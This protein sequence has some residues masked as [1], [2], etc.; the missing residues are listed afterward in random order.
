[1]KRTDTNH[2]SKDFYTT[3]DFLTRLGRLTMDDIFK[4]LKNRKKAFLH[5]ECDLSE[6]HPCHT[7]FAYNVFDYPKPSRKDNEKDEQIEYWKMQKELFPVHYYCEL[8]TGRVKKG[9]QVNEEDITESEFEIKAYI[10]LH[11]MLDNAFFDGKVDDGLNAH[12]KKNT[13]AYKRRQKELADIINSYS[14]HM[15][16][17]N[18]KTR[19]CAVKD[20]RDHEDIKSLNARFYEYINNKYYKTAFTG[21]RDTDGNW[22]D[23]WS[24]LGE[25]VYA[26][27]YELD[28]ERIDKNKR[29]HE[30]IHPHLNYESARTCVCVE[31]WGNNIYL[32]ITPEW[33]KLVNEHIPVVEQ[34]FVI[35]AEYLDAESSETFSYWK[36]KYIKKSYG[37]KSG[38]QYYFTLVDGYIGRYASDE[39]SEEPLALRCSPSLSGV[40]KKIENRASSI[41]AQNILN[42][43]A[44]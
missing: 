14:N 25:K 16:V 17:Q 39:G 10:H 1:M 30:E 32:P 27:I 22:E 8:V 38:D 3:A 21:I 26:R 12:N 41:V 13:R 33:Y 36:A 28:A 7:E 20:A 37:R 11:H 2:R 29:S 35:K 24:K 43:I 4:D 5:D 18:K 19:V 42:S 9:F 6:I 23:T 40:K 44:D 15:V 31:G 34:N